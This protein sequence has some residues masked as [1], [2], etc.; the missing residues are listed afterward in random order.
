M[1]L[2]SEAR[3]GADLHGQDVPVKPGKNV[4]TSLLGGTPTQSPRRVIFPS[5]YLRS[6]S[7]SS[8]VKLM[9]EG[10]SIPSTPPPSNKKNTEAS[11]FP[12]PLKPSLRPRS[13]S[14]FGSNDSI[15]S[16]SQSASDGSNNF[17]GVRFDPRIVI[18]EFQRDQNEY[19]SMWY[20]HQEQQ[21]FRQQ[22]MERIVSYETILL[23]TGTGRVVAQR[24]LLYSHEALQMEEEELGMHRPDRGL[25]QIIQRILIVDPHDICRKLFSRSFTA[26]F[27]SA[28]LVVASN[29]DQ[30]MELLNRHRAFD[31]VVV[32]ERMDLYHHSS[33][34][35]ILSSGAHLVRYHLQPR[36]PQ[37]LFIGVSTRQESAWQTEVD[38]TWTKPPP[39]MDAVLRQQ[40]VEALSRKR[41]LLD[42]L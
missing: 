16:L 19:S 11:S 3:P 13:E 27:P 20:T 18:R 24:R 29:G 38:M 34:Q 32:E 5:Q 9:M 42:N 28:T 37:A 6:A 12:S 23:P 7:N 10:V 17:P 1:I 26:L 41:A 4:P 2:S 35:D 15:P 21:A 8:L 36:L 40:L 22:A 25:S 31:I 30:A 14:I 39:R 33:S